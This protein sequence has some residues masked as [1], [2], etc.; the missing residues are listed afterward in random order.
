MKY[1][2]ADQLDIEV[3]HSDG[4][5]CRL[6]GERKGL[7]EEFVQALA[8]GR[9][10]PQLGRHFAQLLIVPGLELRL[11]LV[12]LA[13]RPQVLL[14]F[15]LVGIEKRAENAHRHQ[16]TTVSITAVPPS[17][18]RKHTFTAPVSSSRYT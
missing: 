3:A 2:P 6:P 8:V 1:D 17:G 11:Q 10:L 9:A 15:A 13:H 14:D 4:P 12:D 5:A 7:D 16:G 18:R